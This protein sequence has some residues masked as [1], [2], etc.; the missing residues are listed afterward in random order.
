MHIKIINRGFGLVR[1]G[2]KGIWISECPLYSTDECVSN[3]NM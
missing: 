2:I 3:S 1:F